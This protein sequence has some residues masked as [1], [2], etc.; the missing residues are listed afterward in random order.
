M[1][2]AKAPGK[3][4]LIGEYAVLY[5]AEAL[6]CAMDCFA[7]VNLI[8]SGHNQFEISSPSLSITNLP[9]K[10]LEPGKIKFGNQADLDAIDKLHFFRIVFE[11]VNKIV[12]FN[13]KDIRPAHIEIGT[14]DFYSADGNYKYGFGSS[15]AM[16]VALLESLLTSAGLLGLYNTEDFFQLAFQIH[17]MAQG[18][19]GSGIDIAASVYGNVL[20]YNFENKN[21]ISVGRGQPVDCWDEL[22]AVPIW[23]G[24]STSTRQMVQRVITLRETSPKLFDQIMNALIRCSEN[25][26]RSYIR[27]DKFTF[28]ES[29]REF[30]RILSDLG[31]KS[32]TPIVSEAHGKL[33]ELLAGSDMVYKPSGAGGGDI[34]VVF[35]DSGNAVQKVRWTLKDTGFQVL[36]NRI[37]GKGVHVTNSEDN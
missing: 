13:H 20:C 25:G 14:E 34:G 18:N 22:L 9:F 36:D 16:T 11:E 15:A 35:C 37:T 33:I 12:H 27:K 1:I 23:A 29:I 8:S 19:L 7:S 4:I 28:F 21:E 2:T 6:V 31:N 5:G 30:N 26:C 3:M 32:K 17:R 24:H 10:V